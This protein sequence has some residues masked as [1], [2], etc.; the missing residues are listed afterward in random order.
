MICSLV[1]LIAPGFSLAQD[2][3]GFTPFRQADLTRMTANVQ[4]PNGFGWYNGTIY[5][6]CTGDGTIYE[7]DDTTGQTRTYIYGVR[8]AHTLHVE[9][10]TR[11]GLVLWVPDF[12]ENTL[13][14]VT[15]GGVRAVAR[16]LPGP[17]GIAPIDDER[18]LITMLLGNS[19]EIISQQGE[20]TRLLTDL[21]SPTGLIV[22]EDRIYVGNTGSTR[23]AIEWYPRDMVLDGAFRRE[24]PTAQTLVSGIQNVTGLQLAPD[25]KLYFAYSLGTRGVVGRVD[26]IACEEAGGC[27][28]SE[29]EVVL[30]TELSAPLA[31]LTIT[32]D[33]RLF[34]H[35]MFSPDLY[36]LALE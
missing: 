34:V 24:T 14:R 4:R 28:A 27:S 32:P 29:I 17:W 23:R 33:S 1:W 2:N 26:P 30:Y 8:N 12:G 5:T 10:S 16:N 9:E 19:L 15:R 21:A 6:A 31:G 22:T 18:F 7:I 20:R 35:E 3:T 11:T 25:G 13:A 36:W